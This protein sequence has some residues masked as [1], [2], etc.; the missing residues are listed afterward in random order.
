MNSI[1]KLASIQDFPLKRVRRDLKRTNHKNDSGKCLGFNFRQ[2]LPTKKRKNRKQGGEIKTK[3]EEVSATEFFLN[4]ISAV[5]ITKS[6]FENFENK[7][8]IILFKTP[9]TTIIKLQ[10]CSHHLNAR[11]DPVIS[12]SKNSS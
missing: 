5:K 10:I 4:K 7:C 1:A 3:W 6:Y 2:N 12:Y 11:L 8:F 9:F